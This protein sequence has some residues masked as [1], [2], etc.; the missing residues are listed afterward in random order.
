MTNNNIHSQLLNKV[1][2]GTKLVGVSVG[3][4]ISAVNA[5]KNNADLILFLS[6]GIFRN[7]G[8]SSLGAYLAA[9]NSNDL[10]LSIFD[11][12]IATKK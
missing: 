6:S 9:S 4:G 12:D 3:S 7:R 11:R 2:K 1:K 8:V 5:S 10:N